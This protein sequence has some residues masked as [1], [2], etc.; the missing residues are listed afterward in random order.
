METKKYD[1]VPQFMWMLTEYMC[2]YDKAGGCVSEEYAH[3]VTGDTKAALDYALKMARAEVFDLGEQ[4]I[5]AHVE[6]RTKGD[7]GLVYVL[8]V[9]D[10][11]VESCAA[12]DIYCH[13][14]VG[15]VANLDAD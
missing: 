4:G 12:G 13:Y 15:L 2:S 11:P 5:R 9:C 14:S 10:D 7:T 3:W 6:N 1:G 8:V